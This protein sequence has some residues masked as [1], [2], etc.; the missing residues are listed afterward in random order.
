MWARCRSAAHMN[1]NLLND[2]LRAHLLGS[3][4]LH[5]HLLRGDDGCDWPFLKIAVYT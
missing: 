3:Q 4:A 5:H 2:L 1:V